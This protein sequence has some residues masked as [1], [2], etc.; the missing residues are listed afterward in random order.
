MM[1]AAANTSAHAQTTSSPADWTQFLRQSM[2]RWNPYETVLG[3]N[4]VGTLGLKWANN[5]LSN[6]PSSPAVVNGVVYIGSRDDNLYALNAST[7]VKLWSFTTGGEVIASPAVAN[8]VVYIGSYNQNTNDGTMYALDA[9]TGALLWTFDTGGNL[10]GV[11]VAL[12]PA[13]VNGVVYIGSTD[14]DDD[15]Y[16][17]NASTG[18]LATALCPRSVFGILARRGEWGGLYR[19]P[20]PGQRPLPQRHCVCAERQ[21][22]RT[23]MG[24]YPRYDYPLQ[25]PFYSSPAVANGVG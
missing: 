1:L 4:N 21:H 10:F 24:L 23:T 8:G 15:V 22:R 19:L 2:Q 18:A 5:A 25:Q 3:V 11:P 14:N 6:S 20:P 9:R 16:A 17:L 7:G 12:W 13:V